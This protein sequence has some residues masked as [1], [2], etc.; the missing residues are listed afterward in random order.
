M[1]LCAAAFVDFVVTLLQNNPYEQFY[2][3]R[4]NIK[5]DWPLPVLRPQGLLP[6]GASFPSAPQLAKP[7]S[8]LPAVVINGHWAIWDRFLLVRQLKAHN[9]QF[10]E[11]KHRQHGGPA[12]LA[13]YKCLIHLPYQVEHLLGSCATDANCVL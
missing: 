1:N 2:M 11:L 8:S 13:G 10:K 7:D 12:G 5:F 3:E 4:R 6:T 9:I